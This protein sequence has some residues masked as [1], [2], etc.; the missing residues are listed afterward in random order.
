MHMQLKEPSVHFPPAEQKP[1]CHVRLPAEAGRHLEAQ[2]LSSSEEYSAHACSSSHLHRILHESAKSGQCKG[3]VLSKNSTLDNRPCNTLYCTVSQTICVM[4][5]MHL[6]KT[7]YH[8]WPCGSSI[9]SI[10]SP[11]MGAN[12]IH[13]TSS[14]HVTRDQNFAYM[15][16]HFCLCIWLSAVHNNLYPC[17]VLE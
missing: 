3:L 15:M 13:N 2:Q 14:V 17:T 9:S 6:A 16:E 8:Q 7:R 4:L 11:F 5:L 12:N 10:A 1:Q